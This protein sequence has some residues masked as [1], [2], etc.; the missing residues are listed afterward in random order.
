MIKFEVFQDRLGVAEAARV[1]LDA[2]PQVLAALNYMPEAKA[3]SLNKNTPASGTTLGDSPAHNSGPVGPLG[4][5][6][7]CRAGL[8]ESSRRTPET[9]RT[10]RPVSYCV[11]APNLQSRWTGSQ[12]THFRRSDSRW[13]TG[14]D[15][16]DCFP[17]SGS[18]C[19]SG[20]DTPVHA[21]RTGRRSCRRYY[22]VSSLRSTC[23]ELPSFRF[24]P[25]C[26]RRWTPVLA[27][28]P[29]SIIGP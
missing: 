20:H 19:R 17:P 5:Q 18:C 26:W 16:D 13:R 7:R 1:L 29:E 12:E 14:K 15:P 22:R 4:L 25:R 10:E 27:G 23:G 8:V 9:G 2:D 21:D 6:H 28:R 3:L 11:P 24:P